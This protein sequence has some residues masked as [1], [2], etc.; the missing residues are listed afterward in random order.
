MNRK[1]LESNSTKLL[2]TTKNLLAF[3]AGVDSTA[4]F[5][6]LLKEDIPFDMAIVDYGVREASKDEVAFAKELGCRHQKVV[7][8]TESPKFESDF[9][10]NARNF[11]YLFFENIIK[12]HEYDT[13]I[14]AHQLDDVFEW[15]LMRLSNGAGLGELV[16]MDFVEDREGYKIVRP[17]LLTPK[18]E[19]LDYLDKN[20]KKYFIDSTN[21]DERYT[22][23]LFRQRYSTPFLAE[24]SKGV[25]N[26]FEYL[27]KDK[28]VL[29]GEMDIKK[30]KELSV[31]VSRN[32][33]VDNFYIDKELKKLGL[34]ISK[35]QR[36]EIIK[37]K[38]CVVSGKVAVVYKENL[39]FIAPYVKIKL[40]KDFREACRVSGVPQKIRGYLKS[41]SIDPKSLKDLPNV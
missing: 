41:A 21:S 23:N 26:S 3:S 36:D 10:K 1:L 39:I 18:N 38:D 30:I 14:T 15:F 31:I 34:L 37:T 28:R 40:E 20:S 2:K 22:R 17:L 19:L 4:L 25:Q 24:F 11:R 32:E 33:R 35:P 5:W 7:F 16:G 6:L 13:L 29:F 9:E 12:E 8:H 27:M